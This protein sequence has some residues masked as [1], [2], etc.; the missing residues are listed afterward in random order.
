MR[1]GVYYFAQAQGDDAEKYR[2]VLDSVELADRLGFASAWVPERHFHEFGGIYPN[3][4]T[5]AAALAA[6]TE[7]IALRAGSVV[8]P[9]HHPAR[10]AEEWAMVD[11]ISRGRAGI[12]FAAGWHPADF[13][14][15]PDRFE[16]RAEVT[17]ATIDAVRRLWRGEAVAFP[18]R[19]G[20]PREVR[21]TPARSS[22]SCRSG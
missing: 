10:I 8:A 18:D 12:S 21:T 22:P 11:N 16:Q 9:L 5:L 3:P 2:F 7:R 20:E 19:R 4:A 13:V 14:F 6:R 15:A 1:F 17:T